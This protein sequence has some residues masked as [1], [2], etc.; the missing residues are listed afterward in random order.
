MHQSFQILLILAI[1]LTKT[2]K[3]IKLEQYEWTTCKVVLKELITLIDCEK[4]VD[5]SKI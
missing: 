1:F 2:C 5:I 4:F 3:F